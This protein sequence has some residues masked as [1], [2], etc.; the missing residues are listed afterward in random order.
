MKRLNPH[1]QALMTSALLVGSG[2]LAI[3][4]GKRVVARTED[5]YAQIPAVVSGGFGGIA[6]VI[7]GCVV[8]FVQVSR[9]CSVQEGELQADVVAE[10]VALTEVRRQ[11]AARP[12][13]SKSAP[14]SR[15]SAL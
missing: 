13:P 5:V 12:T 11:L 1:Q 10:V 15:R 6:L 4:L 14:R 9:R 3:A 2:L 7:L 8:A